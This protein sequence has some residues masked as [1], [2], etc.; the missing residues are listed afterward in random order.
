MSAIFT[1]CITDPPEWSMT[2]WGIL[3]PIIVDITMNLLLLVTSAKDDKVRLV[4]FCSSVA[5]KHR[6]STTFPK[7]ELPP[8]VTLTKDHVFPPLV[9]QVW[10]L[11]QHVVNS[12]PR[13]TL[14]PLR[15]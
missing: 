15:P 13:P 14:H 6:N 8:T 12:W 10:P 11:W 4:R 2:H 3:E 5:H 1:N 9:D 7:Q